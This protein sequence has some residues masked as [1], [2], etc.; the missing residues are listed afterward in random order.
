[1][2]TTTNVQSSL[3]SQAR[4]AAAVKTATRMAYLDSLR[5]ILIVLVIALHTAITYGAQGDWT[6]EDPF[7]TDVSGIVLTFVTTMV[8]AFSLGLYFFISGYF[9]PRSYD[10]K[11]AGQF[12]KDRLIRLG[13]PLVVY[14]F[15]LS[16][17]PTYFAQVGRHEISASFWDYARRTFLT[18][19]DEGPTWF[20]FACCCF[21]PATACGGWRRAQWR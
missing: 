7:Q 12:W 1:M 20:I 5:A 6:F 11:G 19:A 14:T 21:W 13:I 17:I 18:G 2:S 8:Q 15:A 4:P 10:R 3:A 9:T 16:R